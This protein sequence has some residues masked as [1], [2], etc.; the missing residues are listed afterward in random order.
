M[1]YIFTAHQAEAAPLIKHL[2]LKQDFSYKS[3]RVYRGED[4]SLIITGIGKMEAAIATTRILSCE[5]AGSRR[6][7]SAWA[8]NIGISG[9]L[10]SNKSIGSLHFIH[11]ISDY[12]SNMSY[13][14]DSLIRHK[15]QEAALITVDSPATRDSHN[16]KEQ[17]SSLV[18]MEAFGFFAACVKFLPS[19]QITCLKIVS[20]HMDPVLPSQAF[21][22]ELVED[23]TSA[24]LPLLETYKDF[25]KKETEGLLPA[26]K[27]I[28]EELTRDLKLTRSQTDLLNEMSRAYLMRKDGNLVFLKQYSL[29][30][31]KTK[32]E[33][34]KIF[35]S[36]KSALL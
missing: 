27:N 15:L 6:D 24:I 5:L 21:V 7:N 36:V 4:L 12:S 28:L 33:V 16:F 26:D 34:K 25:S 30:K 14:P 1:L 18:D 20:D 29:Q 9:S 13:F 2:G 32:E 3:P 8:I 11:K 17:T 19:S 35:E 23:N 10:D 22:S 31:P